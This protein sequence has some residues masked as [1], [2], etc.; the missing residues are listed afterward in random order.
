MKI[1]TG[2]TV[3]ENVL[4]F[5]E[6]NNPVTG[7]SFDSQI[8]KDGILYT[9]ITVSK[10]LSNSDRALYTFSWSAST[11]GEYQLYVKN[12]NTTV[13]FMS[14]VFSVVSDDEAN[15]TVYVGL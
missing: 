12:N 4:S 15:L 6:Y 5:D 9:G 10:T 13:L 14:D 11:F 3:Y 2:N 1:A 7:V 8:F